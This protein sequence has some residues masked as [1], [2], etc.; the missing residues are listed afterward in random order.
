MNKSAEEVSGLRAAEAHR[1]GDPPAQRIGSAGI[2]LQAIAQIGIQVARCSET[3][4]VDF[5]I[6]AGIYKLVQ[7]G[8][9]EAILQAD[10][11]RIGFAGKRNPA[12]IRERPV[13]T[14][15]RN[16]GAAFRGPAGQCGL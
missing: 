12:A 14:T 1:R 15:E 13:G 11:T 10:L 16:D 4:A 5:R 3:N 8:W 6:L 7:I 2:V 9:I